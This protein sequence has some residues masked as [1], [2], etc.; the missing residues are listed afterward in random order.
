[1]ALGIR[2]HSHSTAETGID[3]RIAHVQRHNIGQIQLGRLGLD[4]GIENY[5]QTRKR[6]ALPN[7]KIEPRAAVSM[8]LRTSFQGGSMAAG[9]V[10]D[11]AR[12]A[13]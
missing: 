5:T 9:T 7:M 11:L 10:G 6:R 1:M 2:R 12:V 4:S 3:L 8:S 13:D